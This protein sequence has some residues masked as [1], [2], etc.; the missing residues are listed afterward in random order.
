MLITSSLVAQV[1]PVILECGTGIVRFP[2][3][4]H[5]GVEATRDTKKLRYMALLASRSVIC[6]PHGLHIS[7][8]LS[9]AIATRIDP[10]VI[11]QYSK[12]VP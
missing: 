8:Y 9:T 2:W 5:D 4:I 11:E 10:E 12:S 1:Y 6:L 7:L 3:V